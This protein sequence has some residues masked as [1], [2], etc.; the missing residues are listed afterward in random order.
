VISLHDARFGEFGHVC[1]RWGDTA[2]NTFHVL[3][4]P[5]EIHSGQVLK[6]A[7][8]GGQRASSA[9]YTR[10]SL[11]LLSTALT[12]EL[13]SCCVCGLAGRLERGRGI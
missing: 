8:Q 11:L 2:A 7:V 10:R 5:V 3:F 12:S 13:N 9:V 6:R 4:V 1:T